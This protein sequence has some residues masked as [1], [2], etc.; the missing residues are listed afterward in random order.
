MKS[1]YAVQNPITM[2]EL[3]SAT[4]HGHPALDVCRQKHD[5]SILNDKFE[6]T[7]FEVFQD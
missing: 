6:V 5:I 2:A 1:T 7:A 4:S 3:Q